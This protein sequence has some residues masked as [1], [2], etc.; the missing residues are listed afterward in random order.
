MGGGG[1]G[2]VIGFISSPMHIS[3]SGDGGKEE[4]LGNMETK[5][6]TPLPERVHNQ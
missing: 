1:G 5:V 6:S 2:G 4:V 3:A